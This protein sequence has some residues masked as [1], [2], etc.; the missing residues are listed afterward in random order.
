MGRRLEPFP[1]CFKKL[2]VPQYA[3]YKSG[4]APAVSV[5][6]YTKILTL[7]KFAERKISTNRDRPK[8]APYLRLKKLNAK[9]LI[10]RTLWDFSTSIL[11][12]NSKKLRGDLW[13]NFFRKVAQCRNKM[14]GD[15]LVSPGNVCYAEKEK[16]F[17]VQFLD[18]QVQ[19]KFCRTFG[20][21]IL[22]TA[23][24]SKKNTDEKP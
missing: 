17:L 3:K 19:F 15:P 6:S 14:T 11:S 20:R 12:Q 1:F 7:V 18:L 16:P 13:W 5:F 23:G 22:V 21:T 24:V 2:L 4:T 8:S 10:G 9:K